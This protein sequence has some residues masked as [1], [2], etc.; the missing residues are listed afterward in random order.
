[1][2]CNLQPW[3]IGLLVFG[4]V[5]PVGH[6]VVEH[7]AFD[8]GFSKEKCLAAWEKIGAAPGTRKCLPSPKVQQEL[9]DAND[10]IN[11]MA[12]MMAG[13]NEL[14]CFFLN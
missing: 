6:C 5:D 11:D 13:A 14:N 12:K 1:M 9:G 7:N 2:P 10:E 4:G 8:D 3:M